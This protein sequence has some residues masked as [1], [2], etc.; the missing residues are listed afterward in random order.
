MFLHSNW[1]MWINNGDANIGYRKSTA[2]KKRKTSSRKRSKVKISYSAHLHIFLCNYID[3]CI[4]NMI[5]YFEIGNHTLLCALDNR[6]E[7]KNARHLHPTNFSMCV[8]VHIGQCGCWLRAQKNSLDSACLI[9][10][11]LHI[12]ILKTTIKIPLN[13]L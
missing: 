7:I 10:C 11:K 12:P 3:K 8:I 2:H 4:N 6:Y 1:L 9:N 13:Y 5:F